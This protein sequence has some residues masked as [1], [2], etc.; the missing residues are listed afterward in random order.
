MERLADIVDQVPESGENDAEQIAVPAIK[1]RVKFDSLTFRF[2]KSGPYQISDVSLD[3][4]AG[5][6]IGIVGQSGSGKSTLM[7]LLPRLYDP[8]E[9]RI[10][11]DDYDIA[12]VSLSSVRQQIGI[13]PQDCLLFEGSIRENITM[14]HPEADTESVIR[15]AKAAAAHDFIMELPDGYGSRLGERGA[16]LSGGQRQRIAIAR[17]LLANPNLLVLDEATSALDY[18]TESTVCQNLQKELLGKTVFFITHRLSTVRNADRIILMHQGKVAEQGTHSEL[19]KKEVDMQLYT[20]TKV[21]T[22][23]ST[24]ITRS[25]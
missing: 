12:K 9:G 21:I 25:N 20:T 22:K 4:P 11:I 13:V 8:E 17:T 7:K 16:G 15:V 2:G 19:I 5:S 6:F 1:G 23:A 3:I 18:D 10:L 14:N 24:Q